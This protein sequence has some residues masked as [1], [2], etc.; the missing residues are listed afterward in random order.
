MVKSSGSKTKNAHLIEY[1]GCVT[2]RREHSHGDT[3]P[4]RRF[5]GG[6]VRRGERAPHFAPPRPTLDHHARERVGN[7]AVDTLRGGVE[8]VPKVWGGSRARTLPASISR[9]ELSEVFPEILWCVSL[10]MHCM[11]V[12]HS[13]L[14]FFYVLVSVLGVV[15]TI[16]ALRPPVTT[17]Q[18][19]FAKF[20]SGSSCL[21]FFR[22]W[23]CAVRS[24]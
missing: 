9:R 16:H 2:L 21:S 13:S 6:P 14:L 20:P 17:S 1:T 18:H 8:G 19:V 23:C 3:G 5:P 22:T 10:A 24:V 11:C 7:S 4:G 12:F 15:H